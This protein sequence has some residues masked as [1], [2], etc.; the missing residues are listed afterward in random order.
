MSFSVPMASAKQL[1]P[2]SIDEKLDDSN[3]LHWGQHA[4]R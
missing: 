3:D 1:F 4:D 2:I